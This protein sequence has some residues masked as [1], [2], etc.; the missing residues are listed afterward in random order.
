MVP[1][2][3]SGQPRVKLPWSSPGG[4]PQFLLDLGCRFLFP[5]REQ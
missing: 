1:K 5:T 3:D 4:V 2:G